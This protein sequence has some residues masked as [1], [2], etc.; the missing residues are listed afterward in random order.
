MTVEIALLF[1]ILAGMSYLF[2]TEKLPVEL[3]AFAGLVVLVLGGYV[4]TRE[5]FSGFASPAVITMLSIFFLSAGF[6]HTGVADMVGNRVNRLIGQREAVLVVAIMVVAGVL[7]AF[8]NNI[9]AAAVLLPAVGSISQRSRIAPSRLFMPLSFGAI[10]GGTTT[11]VGTP[12]NILA[13]EML[14]EKGL[15]PFGLFDFTPVGVVLLLL[16]ILYMT[17][18]AGRLLPERGG[19]ASISQGRDLVQVY[20]L[21]ET[22]FSIRLPNASKL[23]G[24]SLRD[25]GLGSRFGV[26]VVGILRN[27]RR[28]LAPEASTVLQA[29]DV[30]LAK[31]R[32]ED[33]LGLFRVQGAEIA[34]AKDLAIAPERVRGWVARAIPQSTSIGCT[35]RELN[36]RKRFGAIVIGIRR[37]GD[38]IDRD[39]GEITIEAEDD[40]LL[41][42]TRS[43]FEETALRPHFEISPM[44]GST[45]EDL[46]G[47]IFVLRVP[48]SSELVERTIGETRMGELVGLTISGI[49]RGEETIL[50]LEPE[51]KI[52]PGDRLLVTGEPIRIR[53]L[54]NL[55]DVQV[56]Q[57]V[58]EE[59]IQSDGVG[60]AEA[61][62]A[63]RSQAAGRSLSE[64]NFREKHGLQVL[65]LWREGN[66]LHSGLA[67]TVLRF[68]DALLVQGPWSKIRLFASDPDFVVLSSL[69][70][71]PR[72][73]VG[74]APLAIGGL[75]LMIGMVASGFQPIHVAAF[76]AATF[77]VLT[78]VITMEEAYRAVEW[79]AVFLV[80]AV[81]PVG[82]A[83]E[84]TGAAQLL[85]ESVTAM[86]GPFGPY[87]V[88]A[89]LVLL[90]SLLSQCLDGAP[91]VVL[92]TPVALTTAAELAINPHAIMMGI[93]LAASAAFMTPFSHKANLLV[94]GAGSYR[95]VDYLKVG[96]PLTLLVLVFIVLLVPVFFPF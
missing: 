58:S 14:R 38:L 93:S 51:E 7:S 73:R 13:G 11:L 10:L 8:M 74:K 68:G 22:L 36:F 72:R 32:S 26:Q 33:V 31:G 75:L 95:V 18:L 19:T 47:H 45:L 49:L 81:L 50:G 4:P 20:Q 66:L 79:R 83:M 71:A 59:S 46:A 3:T 88:L 86:A 52:L 82:I 56:Q 92:L 63:P 27:G 42:G 21:H 90:A 12:P 69:P 41:L 65:A 28:Q 40:L 15:A 91:A 5:A 30:L 24:S 61:T 85:S 53:D 89:G 16:G 80:A 9:A 29:G 70:H 77:V 84:R 44:D 94:M 60:I 35:L 54:M 1:L 17:L 64:M 78:R 37:T 43:Q 87:A 55:G 96:T 25:A 48:E 39:L 76:T 2:F 67:K 23:A 57:D 34:E 6:L 62:V